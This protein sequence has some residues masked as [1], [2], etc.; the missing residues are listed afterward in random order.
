MAFIII[1]SA[2]A[3]LIFTATIIYFFTVA[4]VKMKKGDLEDINHRENRM[5]IPY[6]DIVEKGLEFIRKS[7]YVWVETVSFDGLRLAARYYDNGKN[8]T[9]LLFH[10]YRSAA[11]RDFCVAVE[12]YSKMGFNVLLA[13]QRA[14]GRSEG[15]LITF[16]VKE[17]RDVISWVEYVNAK[18][19]TEKI[20]LGGM[21]MGATTVL[22][23][24][25]RGLPDN[26]KCIVADCGFS[27][28]ADIIKIV[29]KK[30]FKINAD[31]FLPL[32]D[33]CCKIFGN[34]SIMGI[35]TEDALKKV[36][37]PVFFIHGE[38]DGFVPC[39]MSKK[40]FEAI[41]DRAELVTVYGADHGMSFLKD[42]EKVYTGLEKFLEK[43]IS[44]VVK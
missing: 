20:A 12:M 43:N 14:H 29:A 42:T 11:A 37:I 23:A 28:P 21:S 38:S 2:A 18:Y 22:L 36:K 17:S 27:S 16:G 32:L 33:L 1:V 26:V 31:F 34:F 5:L 44:R 4:F 35:S 7:P 24:C 40:G 30:N 8:K 19:G 41:S 10:G 3:V 25:G 6:R 9:I 39:D 13:D 15:R